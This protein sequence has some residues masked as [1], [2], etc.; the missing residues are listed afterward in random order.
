MLVRRC[1]GGLVEAATGPP[2]A[3]RG[4][5]GIQLRDTGRADQPLRALGV[6]GRD[7]S[8]RHRVPDHAD[9]AGLHRCLARHHQGWRRR[10]A[11]QHQTG[12][13]VAVPL[14]QR[15]GRR[16][17]DSRGRTW[18]N[19]RN[20][21]AL[22]EARAENLDPRQPWQRRQHRCGAGRNGRQPAAACR[23]ARRHHQPSRIA[24]LHL[25]HHRPAEGR[26]HQP[27]PH[28]ELGRLVRRTDGGLRRTTG[29]TIA[30]RSI[31][32]SVASSRPAAC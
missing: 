14:H 22:S 3:D 12:R 23:A 28:P 5:G 32:A 2:G 4:N 6:V 31:T 7:R 16:P 10:G 27:P 9:Q 24:D 1:R 15:R 20:R 18:R 29:C 30:C 25:R 19:F 13:A 21:A 26:Q 17:R 11:D 8:R